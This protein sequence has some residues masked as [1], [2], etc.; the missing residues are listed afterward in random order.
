MC[1]LF[2]GETHLGHLLSRA[3]SFLSTNVQLV[4]HFGARGV[5]K[6]FVRIR[7]IC[8]YKYFKGSAISPELKTNSQNCSRRS[9]PTRATRQ[10]LHGIGAALPCRFDNN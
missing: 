8:T 9:V 1:K 4:G 5:F 6:L 10:K 7:I 2:F 3:A